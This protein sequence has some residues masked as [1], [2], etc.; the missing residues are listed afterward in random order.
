[1]KKANQISKV[2]YVMPDQSKAQM[3]EK[4]M[5]SIKSATVSING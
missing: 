5:K 2:R 3:V 4:A 1:M